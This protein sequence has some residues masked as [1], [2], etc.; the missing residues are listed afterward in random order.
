MEARRILRPRRRPAA[1]QAVVEGAVADAL[2]EHEALPNGGL[3]PDPDLRHE[4]ISRAAYALAERRDFT[5]GR[6]IDDWL[7]AEREIDRQF[8]AR[9]SEP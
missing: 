8:A 4:L 6:E 1:P 9:T 2:E 5:P 3:P 7:A